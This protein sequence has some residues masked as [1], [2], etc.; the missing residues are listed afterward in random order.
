MQILYR[1]QTSR[2]CRV[3]LLQP[4]RLLSRQLPFHSPTLQV[5]AQAAAG[6]TL[7]AFDFQQPVPSAKSSP[8][9]WTAF[10]DVFGWGIEPEMDATLGSSGY[11]TSSTDALNAAWLLCNSGLN[12][13]Q[14]FSAYQLPSG[15]NDPKRT[16]QDETRSEISRREKI[17]RGE[18]PWVGLTPGSADVSLISSS[19]SQQIRR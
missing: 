14:D 16:P 10:N 1:R 15:S 11:G 2:T 6:L 13:N 4:T 19:P 17:E 3:S 8:A 5:S 9:P 18:N 12:N 7:I